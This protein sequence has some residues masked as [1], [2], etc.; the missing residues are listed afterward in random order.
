MKHTHKVYGPPGCGKTHRLLGIFEEELKT[1]APDRIAFFTFTRA[2]RLEALSRSSMTEEELPY[3][4]TLHATAYKLL[5]VSHEQLV[6]QK[7]IRAF[8]RKIGVQLSGYMPD[9]WAI[10]QVTEAFTQP[11][12]ADRLLQ[13]NH[14][15][16]HRGLKLK[17]TLRDAPMELDFNYAKWFTQAYREWKTAEHMLD[18]T[19][20]LVEYVERGRELDVDV[21]FVDEGQDLSWLQWQVL[22]KLAHNAKRVYICGD[23]DQAI[24][25]WAGASAELFN[26]EP[27]DTIEVLPQSYRIPRV[28]H[29][30]SQQIIR[31]VRTRQDK[32]FRPRDV[33]G[34]YRSA[35]YMDPSLID[36]KSTMV[37]FRNHH[38]GQKLG[39]QLE[40]LGIPFIGTHSALGKEEVRLAL[41]GWNRAMKGEAIPLPEAKAIVE[42]AAVA[43][44]QPGARARSET[45]TGAALPVMSFFNGEALRADWWRV[46]PRLPRI[47]YLQR[48]INKYGF[49]GAMDPGVTM[50]S[51]HQS[52]GRQA[53]TV[54]VDL[55]MARRTYEAYQNNPDDEHRV[56]YVAVTRA[57]ERLFTLLPTEP[58]S[59]QI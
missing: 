30:L 24:F 56:Y 53:N 22:H 55:D 25:I 7:N 2:A 28:V 29:G 23:D 41:G 50:M 15:G 37:L 54:I 18:Y 14:L 10:D 57:K 16:R 19:D 47:N 36:P 44:L 17:E 1:V 13:L 48:V 34:E 49:E 20:L 3:V 58:A 8:G 27:C 31:R 33:E 52:K 12:K 42:F 40:E 9:M 46:M 39:V 43:Y 35:G 59:Y 45:K 4:K 6:Q 38:R 5:G 32:E 26:T 11:S 51:I 21:V